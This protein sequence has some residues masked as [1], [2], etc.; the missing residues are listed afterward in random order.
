M[1][2]FLNHLITKVVLGLN[3]LATLTENTGFAFSLMKSSVVC[4]VFTLLNQDDTSFT[5]AEGSTSTRIQEGI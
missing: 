2:A 5:S 4:V 1:T 3:I